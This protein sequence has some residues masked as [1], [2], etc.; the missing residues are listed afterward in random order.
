MLGFLTQLVDG[1]KLLVAVIINVFESLLFLINE[2]PRWISWT[3]TML[4]YLPYQIVAFITFGMLISIIL[5]I[6][7]RN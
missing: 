5:L 2:I 7:G 4:G 3:F 1:F 6:V